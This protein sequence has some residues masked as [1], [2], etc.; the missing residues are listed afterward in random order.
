MCHEG[1]QADGILYILRGRA[2]LKQQRQLRFAG[3]GMGGGIGAGVSMRRE[4]S[5]ALASQRGTPAMGP[6]MGGATMRSPPGQSMAFPA[7]Q[8]GWGGVSA[9]S[10]R[11][12]ATGAGHY[13][14][15]AAARELLHLPASGDEDGV[16]VLG[17][18]AALGE[19]SVLWP[20][21]R[22]CSAVACGTVVAAALPREQAADFMMRSAARLEAMRATV[23]TLRDERL[24]KPH[25]RVFRSDPLLA[26]LSERDLVTLSSAARPL[27]LPHGDE[28]LFRGDPVVYAFFF[29]CGDLA[30]DPGDPAS[31]PRAGLRAPRKGA[32]PQAVDPKDRLFGLREAFVDGYAWPHTLR[33]VGRCDVWC[34]AANM[35]LNLLWMRVGDAGFDAARRAAYAAGG[36]E[37]AAP[38]EKAARRWRQH[39]LPPP[40]QREL[41]ARRRR[42][43][44]RDAERAGT[45]GRIKATFAP[46]LMST[47]QSRGR[48]RSHTSAR[49]GSPGGSPHNSPR[50]SPMSGSP[51]GSLSRSPRRQSG[52]AVLSPRRQSGAGVSFATGVAFPTSP[53]SPTRLDPLSSSAVGGPTG[54]RR[55]LRQS[56]SGSRPDLLTNQLLALRDAPGHTAGT[57]GTDESGED[58]EPAEKDKLPVR[59]SRLDKQGALVERRGTASRIRQPSLVF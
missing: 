19:Y 45:R 53:T 14:G 16:A 7:G 32:P 9:A 22:S 39:E 21:Q 49:Q 28:L 58:W 20:E 23:S 25:R 15:A 37:Y 43:L 1:E 38:T 6:M 56:R 47:A 34:V 35:V 17:P 31:P 33:T 50:H 44:A 57:G 5:S 48:L 30:A 51:R 41:I 27:V 12:A 26:D 8:S 24:W 2:A 29:L 10:P 11:R 40:T 18:G 3:A 54:G 55:P 42:E 4:M 36:A 13:G 46:T 52:A 59:Q